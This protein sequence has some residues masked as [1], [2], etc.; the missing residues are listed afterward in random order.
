MKTAQFGSYKDLIIYQKSKKLTIDII[1]YFSKYKL[2]KT[3]EFLLGQLFRAISSI[4]ANIAE[5]YGRHYKGSFKQFIGMARGSCFES[6]YWLEIIKEL[7]EF[8]NQK[9]EKFIKRNNEL[10]KML[11]A[12]MKNLERRSS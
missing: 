8:D 4:G 1:Y 9:I 11:T 2:P 10:I 12:F 7:R 5:G 3:K 6:D